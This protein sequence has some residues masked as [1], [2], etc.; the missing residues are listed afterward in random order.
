MQN[1]IHHGVQLIVEVL[2]IRHILAAGFQHQI[3]GTI[4]LAPRV[5]DVLNLVIPFPGHL[6]SALSGLDGGFRLGVALQNL[7]I[8]EN[9][10]RDIRAE[11]KIG[12]KCWGFG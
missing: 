8:C 12:L 5:G 10:R 1:A 7:G 4:E 9:D 11:E 6:E 3:D 2:A